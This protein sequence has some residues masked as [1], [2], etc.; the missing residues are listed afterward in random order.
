MDK[1]S[2]ED[3]LEYLELL[4][5]FQDNGLVSDIIRTEILNKSSL[6]HKITFSFKDADKGEEFSRKVMQY[7][8]SNNYYI[9]S[10]SI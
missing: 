8:N 2:S 5:K 1:N 9:K 3:D 4:E 6:D 10:I 7:I